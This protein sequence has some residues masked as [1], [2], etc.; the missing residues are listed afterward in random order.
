MTPVRLLTGPIR[1]GKTTSLLHAARN[2]ASIGGIASPVE[3]GARWFRD[4][5]SSAGRPMGPLP[6]EEADER[7]GPYAFA[8]DAFAWAAE[9]LVEAA[10]DPSLRLVV[11]DELGPLE[12]KGGG[13]AP[14]WPRVAEALRDK[15]LLVVIREGRVE[16]VCRSFGLEVVATQE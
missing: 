2:D 11:I 10:H 1:T 8:S 14:H 12:L 15:Q 5:R 16:E 6:G 3:D 9:R 7:I 4:L 13:F